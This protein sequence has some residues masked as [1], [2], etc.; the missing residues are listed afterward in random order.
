MILLPPI[1]AVITQFTVNS[2][3]SSVMDDNTSKKH[4]VLPV[5]S[6]MSLTLYLLHLLL[7]VF[8]NQ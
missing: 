7:Y 2:L 5:V 6:L 4:Y 1:I 8:L 3:L